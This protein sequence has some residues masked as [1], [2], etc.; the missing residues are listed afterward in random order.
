MKIIGH[1]RRLLA[2]GPHSED[3]SALIEFA[4]T[5]PTLCG[6]LF[7]FLELCLLFYS[8]DMISESAREGTRYA[9][10]RGA[11]CQTTA[12]A[13]CETTAAQVNTYVSNLGWPNLAGGTMVVDT[14]YPKGS[15][16]VGNPVQIKVTYTFRITMHF[17]PTNSISLSS[18]SVMYIL[19]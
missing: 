2:P 6:L 18:T 13:S 8:Y 12:G 1:L 3:G 14:T 5:L 9:I 4:L 16:A 10:V 17:V 19:Q 7:C 15:D 11:S